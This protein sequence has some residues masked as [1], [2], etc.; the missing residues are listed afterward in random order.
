MEAP[1]GLIGEVGNEEERW[2]EFL[3]MENC[4]TWPSPLPGTPPKGQDQAGED[5]RQ[6]L[7]SLIP[8]ARVLFS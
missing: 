4:G 7:G 3:R 8:L 2:R 1:G 5:C 6:S